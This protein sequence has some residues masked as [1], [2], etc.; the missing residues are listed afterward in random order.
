MYAALLIRWHMFVQVPVYHVEKQDNQQCKCNKV[1][2]RYGVGYKRVVGLFGEVAGVVQS[3]SLL[4]P[5]GET[6]K[7]YQRCRVEQ[8]DGFI[9]IRRPCQAQ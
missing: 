5:G 4:P 8:K 2:G 1:E 3:V 7:K 6:G 9:S